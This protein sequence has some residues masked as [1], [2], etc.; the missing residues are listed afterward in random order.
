MKP[1][2]RKLYKLYMTIFILSFNSAFKG[3]KGR[4]RT[5]IKWFPDIAK[6]RRIKIFVA[7]PKRQYSIKAYWLLY[8]YICILLII[9]ILIL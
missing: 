9:W 7:G 1:L 3:V 5:W 6:A 4:K 8:L 2:L